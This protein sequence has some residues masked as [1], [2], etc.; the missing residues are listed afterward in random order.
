MLLGRFI[1]ATPTR[2][3][4]GNRHDARWIVRIV[5]PRQGLD[6]G[7]GIISEPPRVFD[8]AAV[9][10][11]LAQRLRQRLTAVGDSQIIGR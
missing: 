9:Q 2:A 7:L 6:G 11:I 1:A 4:E 3:G 10:D 8:L 5:Q